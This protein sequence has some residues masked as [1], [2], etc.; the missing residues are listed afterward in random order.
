MRVRMETA[1]DRILRASSQQRALTQS[2]VSSW[3]SG[4]KYIPMLPQAPYDP[5]LLPCDFY[6]FPKLKSRVNSC[7]LQTL[8]S[9]QKAVDD[10]IKTL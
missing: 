5:E 9:V 10:A 4:E 2:I 7:R 3:I 6:V 8:G 1:D